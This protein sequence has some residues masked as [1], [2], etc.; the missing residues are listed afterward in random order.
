VVVTIAA[1]SET[2][3]GA[4]PGS[5]KVSEFGEFPAKGR[6]TGGVRSHRFLKGENEVVLAWAGRAPALAVGPDGASRALPES[7]ARRDASGVPLDMVITAVGRR[8]G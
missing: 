3:L 4:D 1:G 7:G 2:L 6:A 5:G 8:L